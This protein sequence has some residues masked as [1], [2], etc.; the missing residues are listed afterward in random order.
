[1]EGRSRVTVRGGVDRGILNRVSRVQ[2]RSRS[3]KG[4]TRSRVREEGG[5]GHQS[6][7]RNGS[8]SL[9]LRRAFIQSRQ[10]SN[11]YADAQVFSSARERCT[12]VDAKFVEQRVSRTIPAGTGS[13]PDIIRL[14]SSLFHI[15]GWVHVV[16]RGSQAP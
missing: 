14:C 7:Q 12:E 10:G 9:G 13:L 4:T 11:T 6:L 8:I 2:I 5:S 16:E 1:M 3:E 15:S